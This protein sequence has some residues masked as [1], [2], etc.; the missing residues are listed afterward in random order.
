[1]RSDG[2]ETS[3]RSNLKT[4]EGTTVGATC[5]VDLILKTTEIVFKHLG[6]RE[7]L[8]GTYDTRALQG[9]E[10]QEG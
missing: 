9:L 7:M 6:T 2:W 4:R 3:T 8:I 10:A 1:M 5:I